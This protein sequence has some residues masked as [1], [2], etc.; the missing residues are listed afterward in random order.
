MAGL[1][2]LSRGSMRQMENSLIRIHSQLTHDEEIR[3]AL[4]S[5]VT[6]KMKSLGSFEC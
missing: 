3:H 5:T 6:H 1:E 4:P 2:I